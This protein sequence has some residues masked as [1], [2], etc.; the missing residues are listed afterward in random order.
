MRS[1]LLTILVLLLGACTSEQA[2]RSAASYCRALPNNCTAPDTIPA[3][4]TPGL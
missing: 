4:R 1:A 2:H 3:T